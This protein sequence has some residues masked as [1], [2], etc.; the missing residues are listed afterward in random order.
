MAQQI[1]KIYDKMF[2]RL[3][4]LSS[5][6]VIGL[7]NS[8][9]GTDYPSDSTLTYND[10]ENVDNQ[11]RRTIADS[12]I[13]VN[14]LHSYHME[15]QV[16]K[17]DNIIFRMFNYGYQFSLKNS[18]SGV[19][20]IVF[21]EPAIIYL[22]DEEVLPDVYELEIDFGSQGVFRYRVPACNFIAMTLDEI[23]QKHMILLLPF[24]IM[25]LRKAMSRDRS[26]EMLNKL[27]KLIFNDIMGIINRQ[28]SAGLL[29]VNDAMVL[30]R[31]LVKLY[32]HLYADYAEC[33]EGG[34]NAMIDD[35]LILDID[36][37]TDEITERVTKEVTEQVTEQVTERVTEQ[38]T[39]QV[40]DEITEK[41]EKELEASRA[42]I[43]YQ[44]R[45]I[46]AYRLRARN[47]PDEQIMIETGLSSEEMR[48][49]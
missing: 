38:V 11:L 47:V 49:L 45:V 29:L 2:K 43:D 35:E 6:L 17:D 41:F 24:Y 40:T 3:L 9:F 36:L 10:K 37:V 23:E 4:T 19:D 39:K 8:L 42:A 27:K 5:G 34:L 12:I 48:E 28:M 44:K 1:D 25:R 26:P 13:T 18:I 46:Q 21:P 7:I 20:R 33:E 32:N 16:Y 30:R 15:A 22:A 14:G 31:L